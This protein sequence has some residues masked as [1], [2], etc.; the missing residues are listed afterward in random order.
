MESK[1]P[2]RRVLR[3]KRAIRSAFAQLLTAK[4]VNDITIKEIADLADINRKTFYNYYSGVHQ[5]MDEVEN[6]IITAFEADLQDFDFHR[7]IQDPARTFSK[8]SNIVNSDLQFYGTLLQARNRSLLQDKLTNLLRGKAV[9]VLRTKYDGDPLN[10]QIAVDYTMSGIM[11]VYL[12]WFHSGCTVSVE[13]LSKIVS[14][15]VACGAETFL[16]QPQT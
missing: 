2:D 13:E 3:T 11:G 15:L 6:E 7:D 16:S 14:R 12:N 4:D 9:E 8:L 1:Q 10:L 5:V